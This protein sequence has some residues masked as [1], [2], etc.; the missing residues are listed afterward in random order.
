MKW[1]W[2]L[3]KFALT[4]GLLG[5]LAA[6]VALG[7]AYYYLE[8][9]LPDIDNLRE[10]RL[11]V[12]LK[13]YSRDSRLIAEFGEQRRNPL[14]YEQFPSRMIEAFL[15]AE[16]A[17]FFE[18]PG[19]DW[20]GLMRAGIQLAT[21]GEKRQGGSTIT[22]QVARNFYLSRQ[23][24]YTRKLSEIFLA[25]RI[26]RELSKEEILEL[27]LNKI[28]LGQRAYGVGAAARVYYGKTVDELDLAQT[29]M[30]AGLPKAPSQ[31]NPVSNPERAV[32]R[33]NY[34]LGRML[35]L[36]YISSAEHE[37]AASQAV[38][39][40]RYAPD[41]EAEAP[42]IAEITLNLGAQYEFPWNL[43]NT[44]LFTRVDYELRGEQYWDVL[45]STARDDLNFVHLRVGVNDNDGRWSLIGEVRNLTDEIYNSEWV[46]GG[47]SA[48][49]PGR[50]WRASL[51]YN[52]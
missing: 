28:Y 52:F 30:I 25:L 32:E 22:M 21:T 15:S 48:A 34:V 40:S 12:P 45:N 18:H 24:T 26:E 1:L 3:T 5:A 20:R 36:G 23:K 42:Y 7:V 43:G 11:Q 33:R 31:L 49:A 37:Q 29:A 44:Y 27:Y 38:T 17:N 4:L 8:P 2:K 19:V 39:A 6:A 9:E 41:I 16:D 10:V 47:F 14:D 46:A 51:R 13:V 50:I 35:D